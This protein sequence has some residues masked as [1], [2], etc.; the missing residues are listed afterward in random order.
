MNSVVIISDFLRQISKQQKEL[1]EKKSKMKKNLLFLTVF[2]TIFSLTNAQILY[3]VQT[4]NS[5]SPSY[6]FGSHHLSPISV[7]EE[8][9]VM[10]F[11]NQTDQ[12]VGEI[13]LSM[14]PM[15]LTMALQPYMMAPA[16]STLSVVLK[17]ENLDSLNAQFVKWAPMPGMQLQML[18]PLKPIAVT[19]M[20][21]AGMTQEVM[22]G[23]DP[24]QQLDTY[25][26][27]TAV[28]EDKNIVALETPEYQGEVLFNMTPISVQAEM[29]IDMLKN[30]DEA[31]N[32]ARKLCDAY[33]NRDL[34]AMIE[35]SKEDTEHPE[36]MEQILYKRNADWLEKLPAIL[37]E[38]PS[39]VVVGA[40]HLAGSKGIIQGLK[41]KGYEITPVY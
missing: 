21:A 20:L 37:E 10:D 12:V 16:D 19:T 6:I 26:F 25:F 3:K 2:M 40:L 11:F 33:K 41:D 15:A 22:P 1:L 36:F 30:P 29:L 27:Q 9:G 13:D 38:T 4:K 24:N 8:S 32:A 34:D 23:F 18:E 31:L 28:K 17:G 39:L 35:I 5:E 7:V 14:D